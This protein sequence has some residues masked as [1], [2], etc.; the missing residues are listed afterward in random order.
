MKHTGH[1]PRNCWAFVFTQFGPA[2]PKRRTKAELVSAASASLVPQSA[3][4]LLF[5]F[6]VVFASGRFVA[7]FFH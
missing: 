4:P 1:V 6:S 2:S 7:S 5:I 3:Q